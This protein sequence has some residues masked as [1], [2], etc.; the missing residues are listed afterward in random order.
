MPE[1]VTGASKWFSKMNSA[2]IATFAKMDQ[3]KRQS[4]YRNS[5]ISHLFENARQNDDWETGDLKNYTRDMLDQ[6]A[7]LRYQRD[8]TQA[9]E[10]WWRACES[11]LTVVERKAG[12]YNR[13]QY[14]IVFTKVHR[15]LYAV[16]DEA[17]MLQSVMADWLVDSRGNETMRRE[18]VCDCLFDLADHWT[19]EIHAEDYT[20]FLLDLLG[21]VTKKHDVS[22][23][24]DVRRQSVAH[25]AEGQT[26]HK[27]DKIA[28]RYVN[29]RRTTRSVGS[30][31]RPSSH[32]RP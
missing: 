13:D 17:E 24:P 6:R 21:C 7:N 15:A 11:I 20:G 18:A 8:V 14:V 1:P 5:T 26:A 25:V 16:T 28:P 27:V 12:C 23:P 29:D 30:S 32:A 31:A 22:P 3:F 4:A 2:K 10:D 9:L 19:D